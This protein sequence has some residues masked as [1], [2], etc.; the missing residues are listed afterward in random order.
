MKEKSY[1]MIKREFA[2]SLG[3]LVE[4]SKRLQETGL[5]VVKGSYIHYT[6]EAARKHYAEHVGK[7]FY[8][9]L[10]KYITSDKAYGMIVEG[11]DAIKIIRNIVGSTKD[12]K[13]GTIRYDIP[14]M[15]G[16]ERR[17]TEN[18]VHA[19][20]SPEAAEREIK[21]FRELVRTKAVKKDKE[22]EK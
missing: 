12:P 19:S 20:D 15:L 11:E 4:I 18:V 2:N 3:V 9:D 6:K 8:P 16:L 21:I 17:V 1:V 13:P 22:I 5:K 10:E 7:D 14:E